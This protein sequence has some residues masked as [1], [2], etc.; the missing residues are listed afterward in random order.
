MTS[1]VALEKAQ[2]MKKRKLVC[3]FFLE[4]DTNL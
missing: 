3:I 4:N 2:R 1:T